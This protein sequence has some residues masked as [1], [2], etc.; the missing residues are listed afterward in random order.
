MN[1][2]T[3]PPIT[4]GPRLLGTEGLRVGPI[5]LGCMGLSGYYGA[6]DQREAV[7]TIQA[8]VD[9]GITLLDTADVYGP[10]INEKVVGSALVGR[11]DQVVLATKFG[12]R[13]ESDGV[14]TIDGTPEY[15]GAACDASL[16]RLGVDHID[17]YY[18][19]RPDPRVPIE[20][21][22]GAMA[23]L[24]KA[25]KVRY[26]GLSEA[27][28]GT[29]RRACAVHPIS[30]L[31]TEWSLWA[32]DIEETVLPVARQLDIGVVSY[33]PLGRGFLTGTV[34]HAD[35]LSADDFRK[36]HPRFAGV[37]G[38]QNM[39]L[40][41]ELRALSLDIGVSPAQLALAWVI[42]RGHD[43]VP[44]PG[45]SRRE[46]LRENLRALNCTLSR[47]DLNRL[48]IAIPI[49]SVAGDRSPRD[50]IQMETP[51]PRDCLSDWGDA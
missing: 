2:A 22:V 15:V 49:A 26:L 30:V 28:P 1:E 20:E 13:I 34:E 27:G 36:R 16:Q 18:Q 51:L 17:V 48:E 46:H 47:A 3:I 9:A 29:L 4:T 31:Q 11:R 33:S 45:M 12:M 32:R 6:V 38:R 35:R 5:G 44:L 21:T 42:A 25:G 7:A 23:D 43:V 10:F 41:A 24:V 50:S 37:E 40:I 39:R 8:A 14:F 19:H